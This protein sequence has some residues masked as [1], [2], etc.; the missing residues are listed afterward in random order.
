MSSEPLD[1]K[2]QMEIVSNLLHLAQISTDPEDALKYAT[3]ANKRLRS[4]SGPVNH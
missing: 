3:M 4:I 2:S 1:L